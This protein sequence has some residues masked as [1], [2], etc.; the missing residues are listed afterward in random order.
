MACTVMA[1]I[2]AAYMVMTYIVMACMIMADIVMAGVLTHIVMAHIVM[3]DT[4][5]AGV[6][7]DTHSPIN[8]CWL[9]P[10]TAHISDPAEIPAPLRAD[11]CV[12]PQ[13]PRDIYACL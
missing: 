8:E 6:V 9:H 13:T 5:M 3:A 2:V 4:D 11:I 12:Y 10:Q 1:C 7:T